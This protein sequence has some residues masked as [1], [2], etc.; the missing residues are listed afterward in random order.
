MG[1]RRGQ[2]GFEPGAWECEVGGGVVT[3]ESGTLS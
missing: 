3:R 2:E 1:V